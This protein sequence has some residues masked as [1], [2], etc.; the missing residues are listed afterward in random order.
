[1]LA[2]VERW[3]C[4]V[5]TCSPESWWW[6]EIESAVLW[7]W[8]Q[9]RF[10]VRW[11]RKNKTFTIGSFSFSHSLAWNRLLCV[12]LKQLHRRSHSQYNKIVITTMTYK[13]LFYYSIPHI[14]FLWKLLVKKKQIV[15]SHWNEK[16]PKRHQCLRLV[17]V[18][19]TWCDQEINGSVINR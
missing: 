11:V 2:R 12:F 3:W 15:E 7:W 13:F 6:T 10:R 19:E 17:D 16:I 14:S 8:R 5:K 1:M 9:R 4:A 18:K